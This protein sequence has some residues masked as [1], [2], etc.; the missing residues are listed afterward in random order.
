MAHDRISYYFRGMLFY[1]IALSELSASSRHS[2]TNTNYLWLLWSMLLWI[3]TRYPFITLLSV[4]QTIYGAAGH[5][6]SP[7]EKVSVG[8]YTILLP[9]IYNTF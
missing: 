7:R 6:A 4:V 8:L 5:M 2:P 1:G 9:H 3:D